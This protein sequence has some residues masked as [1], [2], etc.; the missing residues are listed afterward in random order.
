[1]GLPSVFLYR[2][3]SWNMT[4]CTLLPLAVKAAPI[5]LCAYAVAL[6]YLTLKNRKD[7]FYYA[8]LGICIALLI[9]CFTDSYAEFHGEVYEEF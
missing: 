4:V 2:G 8:Y 9:T 1:M 3:I 5:I 6:A 7:Y